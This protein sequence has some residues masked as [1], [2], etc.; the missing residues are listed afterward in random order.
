MSQLQ[1]LTASKI[2]DLFT[3]IFQGPEDT[4]LPTVEQWFNPEYVQVTDGVR[5]TFDEF[6]DHLKK[7]RSLVKTLSVKVMFLVQEDRKIADRHIV[8]IEKVDG[9]KAVL[10]VLLLGERD[11]HGRF[12][13]VWETSRTLEGDEASAGLATI[14]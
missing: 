7:L 10:E 12:V 5:S 13:K 9:S 8:S 3:S 11:D 1:L 6:V 14:R 4:L 2:E